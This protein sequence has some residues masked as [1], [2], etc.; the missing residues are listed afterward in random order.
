MIWEPNPDWRHLDKE[1]TTL[2]FFSSLG[3]QSKNCTNF[4]TQNLSNKGLNQ[5]IVLGFYNHHPLP[6]LLPGIIKFFG[7]RR[8]ET[9]LEQNDIARQ[10]CNWG[11]HVG[12]SPRVC[13][14]NVFIW[15]WFALNSLEEDNNM[16]KVRPLSR[17][18]IQKV[19]L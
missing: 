1:C 6:T 5:L 2:L 14:S 19:N 11:S 7:S 18:H 4:T 8:L 13:L 15:G 9:S 16:R 17:S 10:C 12:L 3:A